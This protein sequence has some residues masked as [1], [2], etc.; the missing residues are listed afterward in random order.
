M[1]EKNIR[2]DW[3]IA[4]YQQQLGI[5]VSK[6]FAG[7]ESIQ[8]YKCLDTGYR[9]YYPFNVDGDG[10][11]YEALQK[12]DWYY[13]DWKWEHQ[14]TSEMI[15]PT[16][17][18]LEIG[19]A[20]GGFLNRVKEMGAESVGLELNRSAAEA[21]HARGLTVLDQSIQECARKGCH[22]GSQNLPILPEVG[23]LRIPLPDKVCVH[24]FRIMRARILKSTI[25]CVHF[26]LWSI[27]RRS[28]RFC[29]RQ[30]MH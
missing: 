11:F 4:N 9:F 17:K 16:D 23:R 27:L 26:K 12:F 21:A 2:C 1:F 15:K 13:M 3:L 10:A 30:L 20:R 18:V 29:R 8:I 24:T 19:C 5:D 6:Y 22:D 14:I 28:N 7:L 25:W